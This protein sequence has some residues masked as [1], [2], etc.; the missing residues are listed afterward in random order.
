MQEMIKK[1]IKQYM[2][3]LVKSPCL[4]DH[5]CTYTVWFMVGEVLNNLIAIKLNMKYLYFCACGV[6]GGSTLCP[7]STM[8]N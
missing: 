8:N 6:C 4:N 2:L 1:H 5:Y 3:L 7:L